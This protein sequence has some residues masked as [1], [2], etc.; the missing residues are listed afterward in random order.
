M[1]PRLPRKT[2][3]RSL[4]KKRTILYASLVFLA[5]S[6]LFI[7][8]CAASVAAFTQALF[9]KSVSP[10]VVW[11]TFGT[12]FVLYNTQ[13][14]LLPYLTLPG[15]EARRQWTRKKRVVLLL[16]LF[17]G[18][19]ELYPL[20][21][22][23]WQFLLTYAISGIISLLYFLP[24]SNLRSIPF[25]KSFIIGL[26]WTLICVVAPLEP[27]FYHRQQVYFCFSQLLFI[28]ALCVL[29]NIRD[30]EQ[31][32]LAGTHTVPVLY[33]VKIARAF[34]ILLL[35]VYLADSY[36]SQPPFLF[37]MSS[38][39]TFLLGVY[40]TVSSRP[41]RHSFFYLLG[42]DGIILVQSV[43]GILALKYET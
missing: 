25:L 14:L 15:A 33:G 21:F 6:N 2:Q 18:L 5:H 26:V 8:L 34:T 40:F 31:D 22:C 4:D 41:G 19:S 24:F 42:V 10:W 37:F 12:T 39:T 7:S 36:L 9:L 43:L 3:K 16:M 27:Q 38:F 11:I 13:H 29:F 30:V 1:W 23:S 17:L 32:K 20:C 35:L 28:T